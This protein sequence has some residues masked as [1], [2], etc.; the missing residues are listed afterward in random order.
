MGRGSPE[1]VGMSGPLC[2]SLG[3]Q[4]RWGAAG[5]WCGVSPDGESQGFGNI[6]AHT[7]FVKEIDVRKL[8]EVTCQPLELQ[9]CGGGRGGLSHL[10]GVPLPSAVTT[11]N[12]SAAL[13]QAPSQMLFEQ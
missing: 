1:A 3:R 8:S 4:P 2:G 12:T 6:D 11:P 5:T 10:A 7:A 13:F 9:R